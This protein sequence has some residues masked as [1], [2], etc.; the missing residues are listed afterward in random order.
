MPHYIFICKDCKK[1]FEVVQHIDDL[2]KKPVACP[3]CG[4]SNT[5][6]AAASFSAVTS[7]KS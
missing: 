5:A 3:A 7:K 1:E 2:G 6:Q 4:S